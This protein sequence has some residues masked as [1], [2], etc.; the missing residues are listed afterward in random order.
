MCAAP[1]RFVQ[2]FSL[3]GFLPS[4]G[5]VVFHNFWQVMVAPCQKYNNPRRM[6]FVP[7][8]YLNNLPV[9]S[10]LQSGEA[11]VSFLRSSVQLTPDRIW[12]T[13]GKLTHDFFFCCF[14]ILIPGLF[15][16]VNRR[17][18]PGLVKAGKSGNGSLG[19][20]SHQLVSKWGTVR[21][22][23]EKYSRKEIGPVTRAVL[24]HCN[25]S[26]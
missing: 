11:R 17:S 12:N 25:L 13:N 4:D 1:P 18:Q 6:I 10:R 24:L 20:F 8:S 26:D 2:R 3:G 7:I 9:R 14:F 5:Y 19:F 15:P 21:E 23:E 16:T 22:A